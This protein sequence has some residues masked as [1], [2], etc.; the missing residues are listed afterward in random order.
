MNRAGDV[1]QP[2]DVVA[3]QHDQISAELVRLV[4]DQPDSIDVHP[5]FASM[6]IRNDCNAEA[7]V[8]RPVSKL[9]IVPRGSLADQR[10]H[11]HAICCRCKTSEAERTKPPQEP[12]SRDHGLNFRFQ[13]TWWQKKVPPLRPAKSWLACLMNQISTPTELSQRLRQVSGAG[14]ALGRPIEVRPC[15]PSVTQRRS[16]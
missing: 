3:K 8:I 11:N 4:Y 15:R 13:S 5:W 2:G 14:D 6:Q 12:A 16:F 1:T 7:E 10:L 9:Q